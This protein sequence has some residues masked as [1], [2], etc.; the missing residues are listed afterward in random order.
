MD[1]FRI[2]LYYFILYYFID[3]NPVGKKLKRRRWQR[4]VNKP[5]PPIHQDVKN[6][7]EFPTIQSSELY[8]EVNTTKESLLS[9]EATTNQIEI[10][11]EID[12]SEC[13]QNTYTK[14]NKAMGKYTH[15]ESKNN[16]HRHHAQHEN[17]DHREYVK[18]EARYAKPRPIV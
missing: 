18:M 9:S 6:E 1:I 8:T 2:V 17:K 12:T 7:Y 16:S 10:Y 14:F 5:L 13:N 15:D 4:N 3:L 11:S